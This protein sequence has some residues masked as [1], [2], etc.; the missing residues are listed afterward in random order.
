MDFATIHR[1]CLPAAGTRSRSNRRLVGRKSAISENSNP[2]GYPAPFAERIRHEAHIA[3]GTVGMI[4][5]AVQA[6][7]I[8]RTGQAD[9]VLL[10]REML[11]DP[12]FPL[13]AARELKQEIPWPVQYMRAAEG[14]PSAR[15]PLS[16]F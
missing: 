14:R 9:L 4:T 15:K 16:E 8:I 1:T 2:P 6:D 5:D 12:Y 13:K 7:H 11:C 10:A 3:T